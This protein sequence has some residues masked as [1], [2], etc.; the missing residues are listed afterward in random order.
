MSGQAG[1]SRPGRVLRLLIWLIFTSLWTYS[2]LAPQPV[3]PSDDPVCQR[4]FAQ[5]A[6]GT[7]VAVYFLYAVLTGWLR[8]AKPTRYYFFAFLMVHAALI[9]YCQTFFP[10]RHASWEDFGLDV[11]GIAVGVVFNSY[12]WR[13]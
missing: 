10:W 13:D 12:W 6:N 7:H 3:Q 2:L 9:E 11:A 1:V 8:L 5:I 4:R